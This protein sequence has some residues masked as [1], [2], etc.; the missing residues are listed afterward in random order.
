MFLSIDGTLIV[1]VVNFV[2][3]I[4]LLNFVFLR[5]VGRVIAERRAYIDGIARDI[6]SGEAEVR[7]LRGQADDRRAAARREAEAAITQARG[8]A[9]NEAAAV[10]AEYQGRAGALIE[11]R[12]EH[13]RGR[14]SLGPGRRSAA[15]RRPRADHARAGHRPGSGGLV[16]TGTSHF[17]ESVALWS[18]V[19][20]AVAFLIVVVV[21]FRKYLAPAVKA[22][23]VARNAE[24][25]NA[26]K[27][28]EAVRARL[29]RRAVQ[30]ETAESEAAEIRARIAVVTKREHD[31][32]LA[33]ARDEGERLIRNAEGE[34]E[35][36][37]LVARDRLRIELIEQ[38][39][40]KARAD[41]GGRVDGATN[42]RLVNETVDDLARGN[43]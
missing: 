43:R 31:N 26:E 27:R 7:T 18:Q 1:Q 30:V 19:A 11:R 21:L 33:G 6:E 34:L 22:N 24:I 3:F 2:V 8:T 5:P 23:Q 20:G 32:L 36:A 25:A 9:Q 28:R 41:A 17:F 29:A 12:A 4:I 35:R 37:R 38:A 39:L 15:R 16:E 40:A 10:L 42:A 13:R 14:D